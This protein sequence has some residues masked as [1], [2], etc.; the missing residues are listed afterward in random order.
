M[1][2]TLLEADGQASAEGHSKPTKKAWLRGNQETACTLAWL[3]TTG[4]A[5]R[6]GPWV[7]AR[8]PG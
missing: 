4:S 3:R 2:P 8:L 5:G 7:N 1:A 6:L